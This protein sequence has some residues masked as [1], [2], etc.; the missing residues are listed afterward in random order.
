MLHVLYFW[1]LRHLQ[2]GQETSREDKRGF[3]YF[4]IFHSA[5]IKVF[6]SFQIDTEKIIA[7]IHLSTHLK[8]I[9]G[10][11][12]KGLNNLFPAFKELTIYNGT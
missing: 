10:N 2:K 12:N 7:W 9:A 5:V 8:K 11:R 3:I 6:I 4:Y 1:T